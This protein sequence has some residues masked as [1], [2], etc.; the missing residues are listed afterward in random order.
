MQYYKNLKIANIVKEI[1]K[2]S[3]IAKNQAY[4][5][6]QNNQIVIDQC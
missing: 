3:D 2:D 4:I 1:D 5:H 6:V